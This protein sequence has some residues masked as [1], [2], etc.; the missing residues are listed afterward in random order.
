MDWVRNPLVQFLA[1]V[2][3]ILVAAVAG[4]GVLGT[5]A[6]D[7]EAVNDARA[8]T[9]VLAASVAQP[10]IPRGLVRLDPAAIDRLDRFVL[11]RLLVDDVRRIKIW[12]R[13]GQILYSDETRLIGSRYR[14]GADERRVLTT[15]ATEAQISDLRKPENRFEPRTRGLLEVY[16]RIH[17]PEG[18]PLLFEAY[19]SLADVAARRQQILARF[20]P[21]TVAALVGFALLTAPVLLL[22]MRR[23]RNSGRDRE[24]LLHRAI[25][26]SDAERA[27]IARDLHDGVVQDLAGSSYALATLARRPEIDAS[28]SA[29]LDGVSRSLRTSMRSLR[30]LLVEIYPPDLQLEGLHAAL[31]DLL[32]PLT[33][34]G[35]ITSL[36]VDDLTGV[37]E[38]PIGLL[39]RVGQEAVRNAVRHARPARVD[40]RVER[41]H[42]NVVLTVADDGAGF[43]GRAVA[44]DR[45][46]LRG[47]HGL[48]RDAGGR[49]DVTSQ[50]GSGTSVSVAVPAR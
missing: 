19:Y 38:D 33:A 25:Q 39:W 10:G 30:S 13:T 45:F 9:R 35:I 48:V 18:Q 41:D 23:I 2:G 49:L 44:S 42:D 31:T 40:I 16:T 3:V 21:I 46:G 34:R 8:V 24:R 14:L 5:H 12:D 20:R 26:A 29:D 27:R 7:E 37:S 22:L 15:G 32:A 28:V 50:P 43:D 11:A 36:S 17:S 1:V 6:A 4:T 47:L